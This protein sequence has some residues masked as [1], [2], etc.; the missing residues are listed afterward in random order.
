MGPLTDA[1]RKLLGEIL[2]SSGRLS[3]LA[4]EMSLL[5][6]MVVG[7]VKFTK[8]P[9]ALAP[10]IEGEIPG[11]PTMPD[12]QVEIRLMDAA[13]GAMV[14][15]DVVR[16]RKA[17]NAL[18]FGHRR[19]I[20]ASDVLAVAIDPA[21]YDGQEMIRVTLAGDDRI[22]EVRRL[23][24]SDLSPFVEFRGGVGFSLA[25]ARLVILAHG[26]QIFSKAEPRED[27]RAAPMVQGGVILLP[28]A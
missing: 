26:G 18:L 12:R 27:P 9:V 3:A 7:N 19:E 2:T 20:V 13:P 17:V 14:D 1:Q 21:T 23:A 24:P 8:A 16:L 6:L 15:C 11:V 22:E 28:Q 25:I 4:D 10:L 5:A